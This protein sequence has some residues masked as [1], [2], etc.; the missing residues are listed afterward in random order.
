MQMLEDEM[1]ESLHTGLSQ[2]ERGVKWG[3]RQFK[4]IDREKEYV[5]W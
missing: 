4:D 1:G 2:W 3:A 5:G